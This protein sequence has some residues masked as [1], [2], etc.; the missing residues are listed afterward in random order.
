[1]NQTPSSQRGS[2]AYSRLPGALWRKCLLEARLLLAALAIVLFVFNALFLKALPETFER[3]AGVPF[4]AIATPSGRLAMA[5]VDPVTIFVGAAWSIARG[6]DCIS[7]EIGRGTMELL[8]AQPVRRVAIVVVHAIV[9]TGGAALLAM[10][11]WSG[12]WLGVRIT[13]F[14]PEVEMAR[15]APSALNLFAFMFFLAAFS[16]LVSACGN[17]RRR[18]VGFLAGFYL[19]QLL[20]K[21]VAR[22]APRFGWLIYATFLGAFEP[23]A[24]AIHRDSALMELAW[25]NGCLIGLGL[26]AYTTAVAVFSHRDLPAPL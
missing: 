25:S 16:T 9:T 23:Q 11:G 10:A 1:V 6:S 19:I 14:A 7:G 20:M 2:P 17:D 21:I 15:F 8:L 26:V 3:V 5:Y 4:A 22:T 12:M 18:T 24:L 13:S